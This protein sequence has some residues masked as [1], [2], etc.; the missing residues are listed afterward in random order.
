MT[1][2]LASFYGRC[3]EA[4]GFD[5][6]GSVCKGKANVLRWVEPGDSFFRVSPLS[7]WRIT[8]R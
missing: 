3:Q 7:G 1:A 6:D 5:L 8:V 2:A 4:P